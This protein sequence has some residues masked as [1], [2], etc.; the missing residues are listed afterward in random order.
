MSLT[1][2]LKPDLEAQLREEATKSGIDTGAFV[3]RTLEERLQHKSRQGVPSHL[4]PEESM[5]LQKINQG[6]PEE[7][8]QEYHDLITKRRA[9]A[10]LPEEHTRLI[11]L[12][13]S[14]EESHT[15]RIAYIAE[16]AQRRHI[17]FET[18]IRQLGVKPRKV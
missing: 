17:P 5:L 15:E 6:L 13:D 18:M 10:L 12:S 11:E 4:T 2:D 14:I 1:I 7:T 16:L 8:W 3:V 9:E